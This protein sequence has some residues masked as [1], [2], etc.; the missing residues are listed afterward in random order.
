MRLPATLHI[1]GQWREKDCSEVGW[2]VGLIFYEQASL[3]HISIETHTHTHTHVGMNPTG[4]SVA[5]VGFLY[6]L[7]EEEGLPN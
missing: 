2:R 5:A 6:Q 3:L 4:I 1:K 7:A